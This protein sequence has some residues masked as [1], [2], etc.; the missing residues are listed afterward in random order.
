M[1]T[2]EYPVNQRRNYNTSL[3]GT[4]IGQWNETKVVP[5]GRN[6]MMKSQESQE[7]RHHKK[8]LK[9]YEAQPNSL[10]IFLVSVNQ[11]RYFS[12]LYFIVLIS[13]PS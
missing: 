9:L 10:L 6:L 7:E 3:P 11:L 2:N 5:K 4:C 1:P 13:F 12:G 8:L